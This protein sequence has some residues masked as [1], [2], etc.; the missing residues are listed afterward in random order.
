MPKQIYNNPWILSDDGSRI[1]GFKNPDSTETFS[2]MT[3]NVGI[4]TQTPSAKLHIKNGGS[5]SD[6]IRL[7]NSN[8]TRTYGLVN[9]LGTSTDGVFS[10]YDY[11]AAAS[12]I[13]IDASGNLG[14]GV[15]PSAWSGYK[16]IEV[17]SLG[18]AFSA[19]SGIVDIGNNSY[20]NSGY[21][22]ARTAAASLYE[23]GAGTHAWYSAPSGTAGN[24]ISFTQAMTLDA[25]GNLSV[26]TATSGGRLTVR[27]D[28]TTAYPQYI[29]NAAATGTFISFEGNGSILGSITFNGTNTAYNISSDARLKENI[30][31]A[32]SAS[33]DIDAIQIVSHDWKAVPG[34]H[35]KY[36]V[37][38]QDLH[39]VAPQAVTAGDDGDEIEKTWGVDYSKL[40][41]MLIKEVQSLRARVAQLEKGN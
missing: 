23:Q 14:L 41:P 15:T 34:E 32:P 19:Q 29:V 6:N 16:A 10:I 5:G 33:E 4:G 25:S 36:G 40:V 12:R 17:G 7:E 22:Y 26:G 39:T 18:C 31:P 35:V 20:Y 11:T 8:S 27:L 9:G 30:A 1:V 24:A 21:K 37:V 38:A 28:S 2:Y 3:G 13:A